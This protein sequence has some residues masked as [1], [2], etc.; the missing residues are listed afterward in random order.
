VS[1]IKRN[2]LANLLGGAWIT[3][4]TLVITPLQVKILGIESYGLVGFISTLQVVFTGFDFGLSSTL[5]RELAADHSVNRSNSVQLVSSASTIY[6]VFAMVI[7]VALVVAAEP[8]AKYWFKPGATT[9]G[10]LVDGLQAIGVYLAFRWPVALYCGILSGLQRLDALNIVKVAT[11]SLRL[12][13]G[14]VV[15]LIAPS[16]QAFLWWT[17]FSALI[18]VCAYAFACSRH[19][20][21]MRWRPGV[22]WS[23]IKRVWSFSLS[24]N[25]LAIQAVLVVQ[26]DRL[27]VS[28][29]LSL[30]SLGYYTL[31]Y[32][33]AAGILLIISAVSSATLPSFAAAYGNRKTEQL[34][35]RYD[36]ANRAVLFASGCATFALV[37]FGEE[38]LSLWVNPVA[39]SAAWQ[40]LALLALGFFASAAVS[41]SYNVAVAA[42]RPRLLLKVSLLCAIPYALLL[43]WM[44]R[45]FGRNGAAAAWLVL[46]LAY[47]GLLL[48]AVYRKILVASSLSWFVRTLLPFAALGLLS[49]A[50]PKLVLSMWLVKPSHIEQLAALA[51]AVAIY[52][53]LGYFLLGAGIRANINAAFV[54]A[55]RLLHG[56]QQ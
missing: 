45:E 9:I 21:A 29:M 1:L 2:I 46:N 20:P 54:S 12:L 8:I 47:L 27:L 30:E 17:V 32:N 49:F 42:G 40:P 11:A 18:E 37:F 56:H 24:M 4:L 34:L 7:G 31:A 53:S 41:N 55:S 5:T 28:K 36:S 48:P 44:I 38:L 13:G 22:S 6:W 26:L 3:A 25:L 52:A 35:Q 16:L 23:E 14:I 19:F 43:Y 10:E 51:L 50:V 33:A 15:L 39:A